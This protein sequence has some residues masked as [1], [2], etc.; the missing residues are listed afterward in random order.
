V[1][2]SPHSNLQLDLLSSN[3]TRPNSIVGCPTTIASLLLSSSS[4]IAIVPNAED[5][6]L[7]RNFQWGSKSQWASV[8]SKQIKYSPL[9]VSQY[10]ERHP[11]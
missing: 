5:G 3:E 10:L 6:L 8:S 11:I 7:I 4:L 1:L 9:A 2:A